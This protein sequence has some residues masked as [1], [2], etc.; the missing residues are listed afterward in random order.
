MG[1]LEIIGITAGVVLVALLIWATRGWRRR[2]LE[3]LQRVAAMLGLTYVGRSKSLPIADVKKFKLFRRAGMV[4]ELMRGQF[5][6]K[7]VAIFRY[8]IVTHYGHGASASLWRVAAFQAPGPLPTFQMRPQNWFTRLKHRLASRDIVFETHPEVIRRFYITGADQNAVR[9][10]FDGQ[11][12]SQL[13]TIPS[14]KFIVEAS[15][16]WL[17]LYH[18]VR[19]N[20]KPE[21][22]PGFLEAAD[23]LA[24]IFLDRYPKPSSGSGRVR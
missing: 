11:V 2:R 16:N 3:A 21:N 7:T 14:S 9:N 1:R 19:M 5:R 18:H 15:G 4:D 12:L 23:T 6:G 17:V 20:P 22:I 24:G 8:I 10:F 13:T